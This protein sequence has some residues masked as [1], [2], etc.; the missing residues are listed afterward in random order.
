MDFCSHE[1]IE[2]NGVASAFYHHMWL[3]K[4]FTALL[5]AVT[6]LLPASC[7]KAKSPAAQKSAPSMTIVTS[8]ENYT[9]KDLGALTLTNHYETCIDLGAGKSCIIK[10]DQISHSSLQL[11]MSLETKNAEGKTKDLSVVQVTAKTGKPFEV[12]VGDMTL[13]L[14]PLL[15]E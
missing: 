5:V 8:A 4:L 2:S 13:T 12:A 1:A 10:P 14:T 11:T 15:A 7:T 6:G 9:N 3:T